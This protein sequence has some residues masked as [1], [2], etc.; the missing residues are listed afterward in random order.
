MIPPPNTAL[1]LCPN[2][3]STSPR[4]CSWQKPTATEARQQDFTQGRSA[5]ATRSL[6]AAAGPWRSCPP[7]PPS[8]R[9]TTSSQQS[10]W[11]TSPSGRGWCP[12]A[13]GLPAPSLCGPLTPAQTPLLGPREEQDVSHQPQP[14]PGTASAVLGEG[15]Q[16]GA[17]RQ[18]VTPACNRRGSL[19]GSKHLPLAKA[20]QDLL[21]PHWEDAV[22]QMC[23]VSITRIWIFHITNYSNHRNGDFFPFLLLLTTGRSQLLH[24]YQSAPPSSRAFGQGQRLSPQEALQEQS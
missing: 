14:G 11:L 7:R 3:A 16:P 17:A 19:P 1:T 5:D 9:N 6:A 4:G 15:L 23:P 21:P 10:A 18:Q 24:P 13:L 12:P 20:R 2:S 8:S 22:Q